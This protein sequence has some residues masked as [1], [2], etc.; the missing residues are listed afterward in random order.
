M[1]KGDLFA[2]MKEVREGGFLGFSGKY[3]ITPMKRDVHKPK[4][5]TTIPT[6][7]SQI[8]QPLPISISLIYS[9]FK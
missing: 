1:V 9:I 3:A 6:V 5:A 7:A 4:A 2:W 8:P